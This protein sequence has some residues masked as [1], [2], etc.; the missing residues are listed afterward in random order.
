MVDTEQVGIADKQ[1]QL[2]AK[3]IRRGP[4]K[5]QKT[6]G[7]G[8]GKCDAHRIDRLDAKADGQ[9]QRAPDEKRSI[10][11][12]DQHGFSNGIPSLGHDGVTEDMRQHHQAQWH[13][14]ITYC[15]VASLV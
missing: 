15:P 10:Q 4:D 3:H 2:L 13:C 7:D 9:D 12:I 14:Q 11:R 5:N 1:K 8:G 6:G